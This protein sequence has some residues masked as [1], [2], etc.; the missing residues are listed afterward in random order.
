[1][2]RKLLFFLAVLIVLAA[3]SSNLYAQG[4]TGVFPTATIGGSIYTGANDGSGPVYAPNAQPLTGAQVMVQ[5]Q[6]SGGAF[7]TYGTVT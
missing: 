1:M 5:N 3:V 6:H 4:G 2:K 7:I